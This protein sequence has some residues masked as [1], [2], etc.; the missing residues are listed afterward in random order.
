MDN[1][2]PLRE[3]PLAFFE[4]ARM[5][6]AQKVREFIEAGIDVN[7]IDRR[8]QGTALHH[9]A[10]SGDKE[11]VDVLLATGKVNSLIVDNQGSLA[12]DYCTDPEIGNPLLTLHQDQARQAGTTLNALMKAAPR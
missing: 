11:T 2:H 9:A 3:A 7:A 6:F 12:Y 1:E 4:A 8:T 5:G 10:R